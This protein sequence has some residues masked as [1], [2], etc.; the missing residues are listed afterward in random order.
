MSTTK[1]TDAMIDGVAAS[2]LTGALP[3]ISG[4]SLT[5]LDARDLE[6]ALPAISGASLTALNATELTSGTLPDARLPATLPAKS[7]VNLTALNASNLGSGTASVARGGTGA[8][9]HTANNILVGNG[10][11]AIGSIAPST[12]GNV[13]TSN[14][15]TWASTAAAGGGGILQVKYANKLDTAS[16]ASNS[17]TA[18]SGL[19]VTLTPASTSNKILVMWLMQVSSTQTGAVVGVFRDGSMPVDFTPTGYSSRAIGLGQVYDVDSSDIKTKSGQAVDN[20]ASTSAL[21]YQCY[22]KAKH[23]QTN[24]L[25]K[26]RHSE[27]SDWYVNTIS[28]ITVMEIDS[29]VL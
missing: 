19:S 20:P 2:K 7:G 18:I 25:N 6:N 11:S 26:A 29:S 3:A 24:Y 8:G 10:T 23:T 16:S 22:W 13:L 4:A 9:T 27:D 28:S 15:S 1:V 17:W 21:T 14:G 5:N 12:S